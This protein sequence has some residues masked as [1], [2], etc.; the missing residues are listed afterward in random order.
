MGKNSFKLNIRLTEDD[1]VAIHEY[2]CNYFGGE[3]ALPENFCKNEEF[4]R[5]NFDT[6]AEN[7]DEYYEQKQIILMIYGDRRK[8]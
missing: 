2:C 4:C 8:I 3:F 1:V 7:Y 6:W 5:A